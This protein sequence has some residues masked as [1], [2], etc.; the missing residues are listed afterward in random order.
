MYTD[1]ISKVPS[2]RCDLGCGMH[3][4]VCA[5]CKF[6]WAWYLDIQYPQRFWNWIYD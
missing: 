3:E 4:C 6:Y 5:N 2:Y 1:I